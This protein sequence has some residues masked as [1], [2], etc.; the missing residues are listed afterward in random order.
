LSRVVKLDYLESL[1]QRAISLLKN[2]KHTVALTGAGISTPSGIPDFRSAHSGLWKRY[3]PMEVASLMVFR[4]SPQKFYEWIHPLAQQIRD[5]TPNPAHVA[6]ARL[7]RAG[8]LDGIITQNID[9]LHHRAGS[10]VVLELHGHLRQ[11]MCVSCY[12]VYDTDGIMEDFIRSG[13][14]PR[15]VKCGGVLK[16]N[17][18]LLGEQ[19][20][21]EVVRSAEK[22]LANCELMIIAGS[23]LQV[24]PAATLPIPALNAG[25]KLIIVNHTPTYLDE[26]ADVVIHGDVETVLPYLADGVLGKDHE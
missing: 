15:C 21:Y 3:D 2:S 19:L 10:R 26:R 8:Y 7:E 1:L 20:P 9:A 14:V 22:L 24:V 13:E 12:E 23:S 4:H 5:A 18:V 25:A 17:A 6:L 11:A 16:P